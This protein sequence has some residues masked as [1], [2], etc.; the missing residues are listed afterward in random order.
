MKK[1]TT[2]TH[3]PMQRPNTRNAFA[4]IAVSDSEDSDSGDASSVAEHEP[5]H[6]TA[7]QEYADNNVAWADMDTSE[8]EGA[9]E[10]KKK[11]DQGTASTTAAPATIPAFTEPD[12]W[13]APMADTSFE[14]VKRKGNR[15]VPD[16]KPQ[17]VAPPVVKMAVAE[18]KA[19]AEKPKLNPKSKFAGLIS[20]SESSSESESEDVATQKPVPKAKV[21]TAKKEA[22][23]APAP[24]TKKKADTPALSAK[25]KAK[26]DEAPVAAAAPPPPAPPAKKDDTPAKKDDTPA[27]EAPAP[28]SSKGKKKKKDEKEDF[29][30][31]ISEFQEADGIKKKKKKKVAETTGE[32]PVN[33][34]TEKMTDAAETPTPKKK[35]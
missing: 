3:T 26:K 30:K 4:L 22:A 17:P 28:T 29:H 33:Q 11:R 7:S 9:W 24:Q 5:S 8:D 6:H 2:V 16:A 31:I 14:C 10:S 25:S 19:V 18:K 1:H 13:L 15:A 12:A 21:V 35:K 27:A 32:Q 34:V 23:P 20:S